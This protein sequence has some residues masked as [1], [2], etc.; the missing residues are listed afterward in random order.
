MDN[1]WTSDCPLFVDST[2]IKHKGTIVNNHKL[3]FLKVKIKSL[4]AEQGII[5]LEKNKAVAALR[6]KHYDLD[7]V[8]AL[9][10]HKVC[11]VRP[12]A[13]VSLMAYGLLRGKTPEQIEPNSKME[14]YAK[15]QFDKRLEALIKKYGTYQ[16]Y[17]K[18]Y[19]PKEDTVVEKQSILQ[20]MQAA[21]LS[22]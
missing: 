19:P 3:K 13:R 22:K 5:R 12:E 10:H 8:N 1:P 16:D 4:A 17:K 20:R 18:F 21:V 15:L 6:S 11:V 7:L 9:Q 14:G 2:S